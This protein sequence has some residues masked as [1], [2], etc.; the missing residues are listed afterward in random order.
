MEGAT[1]DQEVKTEIEVR[2][3]QQHG[4]VDVPT[5]MHR[6]MGSEVGDKVFVKWDGDNEV[7]KLMPADPERLE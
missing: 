2:K 6:A 1:T 4:R 7:I 5:E 3:L